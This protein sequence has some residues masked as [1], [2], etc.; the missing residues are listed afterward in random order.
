[1][2]KLDKKA[3]SYLKSS[4]LYLVVNLIS[5]CSTGWTPITTKSLRF[6]TYKESSEKGILSKFYEYKGVKIYVHGALKIEDNATI[7]LKFNLPLLG[8][9]WSS[10]G[11]NI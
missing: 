4:D 10:K 5:Q 8:T 6:E 3:L 7:K 9:F 11:I 1:L 2:I